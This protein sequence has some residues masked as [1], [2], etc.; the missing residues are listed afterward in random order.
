[1]LQQEPFNQI[2]SSPSPRN[3]Q[4]A[5]HRKITKR[6]KKVQVKRVH[7]AATKIKT[8]N[9]KSEEYEKKK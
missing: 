8:P 1:M 5:M 4:G 9:E 2:E 6:K 3:A 7:G